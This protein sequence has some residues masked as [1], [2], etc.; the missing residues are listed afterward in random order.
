MGLQYKNKKGKHV[1]YAFRIFSH[2]QQSRNQKTNKNKN[3]KGK[4]NGRSA[5]AV[6][7]CLSLG[8]RV[9]G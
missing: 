1:M 5:I 2:A 4:H 8:F 9:Q 3:T 6:H 7:V